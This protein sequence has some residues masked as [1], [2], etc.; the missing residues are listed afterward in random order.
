MKWIL[1]HL[2]IVAAILVFGITFIIVG[3][4]MLVSYNS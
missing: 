3:V 4:V 1:N 2:K